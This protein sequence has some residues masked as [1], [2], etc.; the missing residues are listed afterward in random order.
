MQSAARGF[1]HIVE[2]SSSADVI[3]KVVLKASTTENPSLS[4][5]GRRNMDERK[6]SMSETEFYKMMKEL[7]K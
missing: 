6:N 1:G 3:A 2:G 4:W 5:T 7:M